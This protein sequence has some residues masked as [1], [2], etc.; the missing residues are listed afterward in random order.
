MEITDFTPRTASADLDCL[1]IC[2]AY[3]DFLIYGTYLIVKRTEDQEYSAQVRTGSIQTLPVSAVFEP[4]YAG[5]LPPKLAQHKFPAAVLDIRFHPS[6]GNLMGV[7]LSNGALHFFRFIKRADVLGRCVITELFPLGHVAVSSA[8]QT[9]GI[10]PLVTQFQW[11]PLILEVGRRDVSNSL[12]VTL[13]ATLSS[14]EV[15]M[16]KTKLPGIKS[17]HDHRLALPPAPLKAVVEDVHSHSLE[18]W[19]ASLIQLPAPL[20]PSPNSHI[21]LSGGDDSTLLASTFTLNPSSRIDDDLFTDSPAQSWKDSKSHNAGITA[22]LP[23][24]APD[25]LGVI[26]LLTGSYDEHIRLFTLSPHTS[27]RTLQSELSLRGG[28]WRLQHIDH[29]QIL[30]PA[31]RPGLTTEKKRFQQHYTILVSCMHAGAK[32][33]RVT[34]SERAAWDIRVEAEFKKGHATL[35]YACDFKREWRGDVVLSPKSKK[36]LGL[37][38]N[39][40]REVKQKT[41]K[42]GGG[43]GRYTIVSTS[44]YD[45]QICNWQ[46]RDAVRREA[47]S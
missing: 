4:A 20:L 16:L 46:W 8:D 2:P 39:G 5:M 24:P 32:I 27:K 13:T 18:A 6:D 36:I 11:L 25:D 34:H 40:E 45:R 47:C 10:V 15:K 43:V 31:D 1:T 26:P 37:G 21:L 3:P 33:V 9:T 30:L 44:F 19:C 14:G 42:V 35:V 17:T 41:N 29:Y 23:F 7:A 12:T 22:I 38:V 28:V